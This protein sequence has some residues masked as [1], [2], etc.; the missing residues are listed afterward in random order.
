MLLFKYFTVL[1]TLINGMVGDTVTIL[2]ENTNFFIST[3]NVYDVF[4]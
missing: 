2:K 4:I 3:Y 1:Y